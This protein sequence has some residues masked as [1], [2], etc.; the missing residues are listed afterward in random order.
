VGDLVPVVCHPVPIERL[1]NMKKTIAILALLICAMPIAGAFGALHDQVSYTLSQEYYTKFKFLQFGL[2]DPQIPERIR[3]AEVGFLASWWM[4][5]P[6]GML[7]APVAL[8]HRSAGTVLRYGLLGFGVL[9]IFTGLFAGV[10]LIYGYA[11]TTTFD[12]RQYPG[13]FLPNNLVHVRRFLCVGYMHNAAY[14]GGVIGVPV[15]WA[16]HVVLR[17][18]KPS[19]DSPREG[20]HFK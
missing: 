16:F 20:A 9:M 12:L 17:L 7:V 10:G 15:V 4:G 2:L 5:I 8:I 6:I 13:W 3:A 14:L 11:H 18:R 19:R 1:T